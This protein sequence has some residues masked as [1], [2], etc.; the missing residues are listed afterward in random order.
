MNFVNTKKLENSKG[1]GQ[2][3]KNNVV[4]QNAKKGST[5]SNLDKRFEALGKVGN[6]DKKCAINVTLD[7][8]VLDRLNSYCSKHFSSRSAIINRLIA[9]WMCNQKD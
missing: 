8:E 5:K 4:A 6:T 7:K 1:Q 2:V 3:D 9:D